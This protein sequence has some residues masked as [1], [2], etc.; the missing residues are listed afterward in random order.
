MWMYKVEYIKKDIGRSS[1]VHEG[2]GCHTLQSRGSR[3]PEGFS[4]K[5]LDLGLSK[6]VYF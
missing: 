1:T 5:T 3:P 4:R 6:Q 2:M